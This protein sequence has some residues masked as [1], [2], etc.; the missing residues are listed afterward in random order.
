MS[1]DRPP[2]TP[3]TAPAPAPAPA[4]GIAP[5]P[6]PD[7]VDAAD[8]VYR[9]AGGSDP[10]AGFALVGIVDARPT[11][12]A[13]HVRRWIADGRHGEM[14]YLANHLDVRLDPAKL[15]D[16]ARSIIAVADGYAAKGDAAGGESGP[17]R[18]RIARYAWGD[19]YHK[20]LKSRLHRLADRL[21]ER[22][23]GHAFRA[24]VDTAPALEREHAA[25]AGLGWQGKNTMTI[26]PRHGSYFLLG[27]LV[28]TLPLQPTR[29]APGDAKL[30]GLDHCG[31]CTRCIDACPTGCITTPGSDPA[32]GGPTPGS[33]LGR[34]ID[35][36]RCISY[37]TLEHRSPIDPA[38]HPFMGDW[39][40]G[41]DV[42]QDVCPFN[43]HVR[44]ARSDV[45]CPDPTPAPSDIPHPASDIPHP[46]SHILPIH[47]AYRPREAFAAGLP[48][49]EVLGWTEEDRRAAFV[50][51]ALKR[52]KLDMLKRNAL[53][54]AGN[55]LR[56]SDDPPLRARLAALAADPAEPPLVRDTAQQVL[57]T[58]PPPGR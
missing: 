55:A 41:C 44:S 33:P 28:T 31:T 26:H 27:L 23:P 22:F 1:H 40:A 53:I 51:S 12:Y 20:V 42:C 29:A 43:R 5:G 38:L 34:S 7:P 6:T 4:P 21:A 18:G 52:V 9:L 47:P 30:P 58:L 3:G 13:D 36:T 8:A 25:R 48:L 35:A 57:A 2:H 32:P 49:L 56:E 37:L 15:L 16:G 17:P 19:D 54:A 14:H 45:G 46:T 39:I 10:D 24:T 50:R 11:D